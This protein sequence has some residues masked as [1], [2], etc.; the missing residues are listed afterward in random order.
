MKKRTLKKVVSLSISI[1]LLVVVV[2]F[3]SLLIAND[4]SFDFIGLIIPGEV[5]VPIDVVEEAPVFSF[6]GEEISN[7]DDVGS[8]DADVVYSFIVPFS[9]YTYKI[10][11]NMDSSSSFDF[12]VDEGMYSCLGEDDFTSGFIT[13]KDEENFSLSYRS[14]YL[15]I[16][17]MYP[18][19]EISIPVDDTGE[20][21]AFKIEFKDVASSNSLIAK[22]NVYVSEIFDIELDHT[23]LYF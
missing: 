18:D 6:S 8:F 22:F 21:Y 13:V 10:S 11:P 19:N 23:E 1:V 4:F 2:G 14:M 16:K 7:N 5:E 9:D 15:I 17:S 12:Y 3:L 20:Y